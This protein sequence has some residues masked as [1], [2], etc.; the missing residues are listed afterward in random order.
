MY[1]DSKISWK[2]G[3]G[4]DRSDRFPSSARTPQASHAVAE[5]RE[6]EIERE[7]EREREREREREGGRERQRRLGEDE[8][9]EAP[10][11]V[12]L[13]DSDRPRGVRV[14]HLRIITLITG[15]KIGF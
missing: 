15:L 14:V 1:P 6:I 13:R 9:E 11:R 10:V 8:V 12:H 2:A 3:G 4:Y 7:N 5:D